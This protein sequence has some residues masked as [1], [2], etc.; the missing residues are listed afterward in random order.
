M[1]RRVNIPKFRRLAQSASR[2]VWPT[3]EEAT[4]LLGSSA[5]GRYVEHASPARLLHM[6]DELESLR[7]RVKELEA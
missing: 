5:E 4:N 1:P 2:C 3:Q 7:A 6:L